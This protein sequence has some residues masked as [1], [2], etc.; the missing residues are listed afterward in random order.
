M[1]T[2]DDVRTR[3]PRGARNVTQAFFE[4]LD[5]IPGSQ[6]AAVATAALASIRDEIKARRLKAREA[7]ARAKAKAPTGR[8]AKAKAKAATAAKRAPVAAKKASAKRTVP[9]KADKPE[10]PPRVVFPPPP[11]TA[12]E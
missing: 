10:P 11:D 12:S 7:A 2:K 4:A 5:G 6:Q 9:T 8:G 3:A 1:A